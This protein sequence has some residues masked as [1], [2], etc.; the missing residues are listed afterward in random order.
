MNLLSPAHQPH[1]KIVRRFYS[2]TFLCPS[3][4]GRVLDL[5][6]ERSCGVSSAVKLFGYHLQEVSQPHQIAGMLNIV[7]VLH[8]IDTSYHSSNIR[9][10]SMGFRSIDSACGRATS[11]WFHDT[12][13]PGRMSHRIKLWKD[14]MDGGGRV[15]EFRGMWG[16]ARTWKIGLKEPH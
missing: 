2:G 13:H 14:V 15:S 16:N 8:C 7:P 12:I 9:P 1:T 11:A 6:S 5:S 10:A 4:K 3:A